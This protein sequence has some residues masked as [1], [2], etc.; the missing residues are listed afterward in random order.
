MPDD[1]AAGSTAAPAAPSAP[2]AAA[3]AAPVSAPA[4][5]GS[6]GIMPD[7]GGAPAAAPVAPD[8]FAQVTHLREQLEAQTK[9]FGSFREKYSDIDPDEYRSLVQRTRT[10]E[11]PFAASNPNRGEVMER[12]RSVELARKAVSRYPEEGRQQYAQQLWEDLGLSQEDIAL[13]KQW[14]RQTERNERQ[15]RENPDQFYE[16]IKKEAS[17]DA[18]NRM[19]RE[20]EAKEWMGDPNRGA[21]REHAADVARLYDNSIPFAERTESAAN[22]FA[23]LA[24][25]KKALGEQARADA[26]GEAQSAAR[27]ATVPAGKTADG[28]RRRPVDAVEYV[29]KV[30]KINPDS[31]QYSTKLLETNA[32]IR[33]GQL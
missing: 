5:S 13:H 30:L 18:Y 28:E 31:P 6:T 17:D 22:A 15:R 9:D 12:V 24:R 21:V 29:Q 32:K 4:P 3:P 2:V 8:L 16:R 11:D 1:L 10:A 20:M 14:Q 19:K 26:T 7:A 27:G 23:E 33:A 25:L